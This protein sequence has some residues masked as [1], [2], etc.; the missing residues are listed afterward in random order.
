MSNAVWLDNPAA[1]LQKMQQLLDGRD[2]L[3]VLERTPAALTGIVKGHN[4]AQLNTRPFEGKWTPNE[5]LGHYVDIEW[6]FAF[7]IR[8]ALC[9]PDPVLEGFDQELWV[10]R[11]GHNDREP[12]EH[13]EVFARLRP[14]NLAAWRLLTPD[15]LQRTYVHKERGREPVS[16]LRTLHA[17]HDLWHLDQ[18]TRYLDA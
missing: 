15:D 13:L 6:V 5:I 9:D 12:A 17:G 7:R 8:H 3:A 2:P 4:A 11:L 14:Y 16:V 10:T 18:I 1:Y